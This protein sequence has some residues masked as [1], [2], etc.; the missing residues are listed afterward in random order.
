MQ[1]TFSNKKHKTNWSWD[2]IYELEKGKEFP[3]LTTAQAEIY[4]KRAE[5]QLFLNPD[6][7]IGSVEAKDKEVYRKA[8]FKKMG[9]KYTPLDPSAQKP[10]RT[11]KKLTGWISGKP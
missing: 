2:D 3:K 8:Y 9:W 7:G 10:K 5:R 11:R 1:L 6:N 4:I